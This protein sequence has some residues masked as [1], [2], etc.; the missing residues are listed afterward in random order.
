MENVAAKPPP[1]VT[2]LDGKT[3]GGELA[4][5]SFEQK[6]VGLA[7]E[8]GEVRRIPF[9]T[10]AFYR[11][12]A[13]QGVAEG[14]MPITWRGGP[15]LANQP[16]SFKGSLSNT[17]PFSGRMRAYLRN[18]TGAFLVI[19]SSR[20]GG[21]DSFIFIP[22]ENIAELSVEEPLGAML[23]K[24]GTLSEE[25]V[26][27]VLE[28]QKTMRVKPI[29]GYLSVGKALTAEAL[30]EALERQK[31]NAKVMRIGD[32]LVGEQVISEDQLSAALKA[33][34]QDRSKPLGQILIDQG[35]ITQKDLNKV[36]AQK[37]GIPEVSVRR[38]PVDPQAIRVIP[39]SLARQHRVVPLC[40]NAGALAVAM[41]N[42][43]DHAMV[44]ELA[45][46]SQHKIDAV[47]AT[48]EEIAEGLELY[49]GDVT[50]TVNEMVTDASAASAPEPRPGD[51]VTEADGALVRLVNKILSDAYRQKASDIHIE[52]RKDG[53]CNVR[54]RKD[55]VLEKYMDL[56]ATFRAALISR[57]KI[58]A[59]LDISE[60]RKPQDGRIDFAKFSGLNFSLR[61][62]T[63]PTT[64][65]AESVTLRILT[66][67][68]P[69]P[70]ASLRMEPDSLE[71]LRTMAAKS[72]GLV[73]LSGPT[74]SG[75]TT[76]LH[77]V[78]AHL[79]TPDRKIW[80]AEDPIEISQDGL[81][82]VQINAKIGWTFAAALRI[83]LRADP[84]VIM[85]GE[86]RDEETAAIAVSAAL[87]GHLVL[88]TV[89][90]NSACETVT[91]L[92]DMGLDPFSFADSLKGVVAQR[93]VRGLDTCKLAYEP[94]LEDM[95]LLAR[96]YLGGGSAAEVSALL[97]KWH[98]LYGGNNGKFL[99]HRE[100]GCDEC[101]QKGFKGRIGIHEVLSITPEIHRL[102]QTRAPLASVLA[103]A[104]AGGLRTLKQ[105]GILKVL[106]GMTTMEQVRAACA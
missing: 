86:M 25:Q 75:K 31:S 104:R 58:M 10:I 102:I 55:G 21:S 20:P 9:S 67:A 18:A 37:L 24:N 28:L 56:P 32:V 83:F 59:S 82:Q 2:L 42:P 22:E 57:L 76:T 16:S 89:H 33:Q 30:A 84:D 78:L 95:Q 19:P 97:V 35:L 23:V 8:R 80:T 96:E 47:L 12:T 93:L 81:N 6:V 77:S 46:V 61:V 48:P 65:G 74:G 5:F 51:A 64:D 54:F 7:S 1:R 103:E 105:D 60:K 45:M 99:L 3:C 44:K 94:P 91:R 38:F 66:Q 43:L 17:R 49:Y 41:E 63:I 36:L 70:L 98:E 52:P 92:V 14:V 53:S 39:E 34:A 85:V 62:A 40:F 73:L 106:Q 29:G 4:F 68:R 69:L 79:N 71:A 11:F 50:A 90:T 87:T 15:P 72:H 13:E 100:S 88:S 101:S 26:A 27:A